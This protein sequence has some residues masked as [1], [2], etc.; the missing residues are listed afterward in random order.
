M[1]SSILATIDELQAKI[2]AYG[3]LDADLQKKINYKFRL[4]WNFYSNE[5]E[6]NS[7]TR[8]ETR[9]L[10]M[11][12]VTIDG[13][14]FKDIAEMRGH[15]QEVLNII[16]MGKGDLR[17]SEKRIKAMHKAIMYENTAENGQHIGTWKTVNNHLINYRSEKF[18]F[19]P[20]TEVAEAMHRLL[21]ETNA[22]IDQRL[23]GKPSVHPALLAFQFHLEYIRIHPFYDGNGRTARLLT[24]LLLISAGFPPVI[25]RRENREAYYK[26]LADIQGYGATPDLFYDF[27]GRLLIDSQQLVLDAL[28]GKN[29]EE[30]D[31]IDKEIALWKNELDHDTKVI[32]KNNEV[33]YELYKNSLKPLFELFLKKQRQFEDLFSQ[34][35]VNNLINTDIQPA[36]SIE[37]FEEYINNLTIEDKSNIHQPTDLRN[38]VL[39][40][41]FKGF[42]KDR[43]N[44]FDQQA[45]FTVQFSDYHYKIYPDPSQDG[46][47]MIKLYS[48][49]LTE[50]EMKELVK[51]SVQKTFESIKQSTE[52]HKK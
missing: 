21:D 11:D 44:T 30:G 10:M 3:P 27:M 42:T 15:D 22:A 16:K 37:Y 20:H 19:L 40:I 31:D 23:S 6:G 2:D 28:E 13:K 52:N 35:T 24:N 45:I 9:Q 8:I 41:F 14:P 25:L 39:Y 26:H 36:Q 4:D 33:L 32:E 51:E 12:N 38:M 7:L 50:H 29:I 34:L 48:E 43:L 18:E 47:P 17:L 5:M 49:Q 46:K 1:N